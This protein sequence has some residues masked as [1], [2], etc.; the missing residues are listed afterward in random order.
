MVIGLLILKAGGAYVPIDPA[1]PAERKKFIFRTLQFFTAD[2]RTS[3]RRTAIS[4]CKM[5]LLDADWD[6]ISLKT[7]LPHAAMPDTAAY[8][9]YTRSSRPK[10]VVVEQSACKLHKAAISHYGIKPSDRILQF[11]SLSFDACAEELYPCLLQ[12]PLSN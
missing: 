7:D 10:A 6:E 5:V 2:P 4:K 11:A 12:A 9:I 3:L 1:C 8:V